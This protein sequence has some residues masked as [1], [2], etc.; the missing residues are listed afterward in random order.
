MN[1]PLAFLALIFLIGGI[2]LGIVALATSN[3]SEKDEGSI[4]FFQTCFRNTFRSTLETFCTNNLDKEHRDEFKDDRE[5]QY[6]FSL[7]F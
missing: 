5:S 4:G 2:S 6:R 3:W 7:F 1:K